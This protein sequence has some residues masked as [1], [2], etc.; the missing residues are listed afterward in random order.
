M[1]ATK[2]QLGLCYVFFVVKSLFVIRVAV[3]HPHVH[4]L[5]QVLAQTDE[6]IIGH[7]TL[8]VCQSELI[9]SFSI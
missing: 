1:H 6:S 8:D 2:R 5:M 7:W 3:S 4:I 9:P